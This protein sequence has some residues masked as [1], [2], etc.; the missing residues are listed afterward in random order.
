MISIQ[1]TRDDI[2]FSCGTIEDDCEGLCGPCEIQKRKEIDNRP[3][4]I[5][6]PTG[7]RWCAF[8]QR[9]LP[10][11]IPQYIGFAQSGTGH[12]RGRA[13][14]EEDWGNP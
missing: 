8:E 1:A 14:T 3:S 2:C 11:K 13:I 10:K 7:H 4:S 9:Y 12:L 5:D 6:V